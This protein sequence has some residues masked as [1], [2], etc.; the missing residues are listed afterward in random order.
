MKV[1]GMVLHQEMTTIHRLYEDVLN[2]GDLDLAR[3]LIA[4]KAVDHTSRASSSLPTASDVELTAFLDELCTAFPD[5]YWAVETITARGNTLVV[6]TAMS[7]SH[8]GEFRGLRPT[9]RE[10]TLHSVDALRVSDGQIVEHWGEL[11]VDGLQEQLGD[12]RAEHSRD[13]VWRGVAQNAG[14]YSKGR[15]YVGSPGD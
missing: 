14:D 3:E 9:G 4:V 11:D 13:G 10:F 7:G 6:R 5:V 12:R 2:A 1:T 8:H 15:D